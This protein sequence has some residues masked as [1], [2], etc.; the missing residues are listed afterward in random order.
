MNIN[1]FTNYDVYFYMPS[2]RAGTYFF[3]TIKKVSKK[4]TA[5]WKFAKIS[6]FH[7]CACKLS[8]HW[9]DQTNKLVTFHMLISLRNFQKAEIKIDLDSG[10]RTI[11]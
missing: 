7:Y 9:R 5:T 1:S 2:C 11:L 10:L 3:S 8:R 4:I 6:I